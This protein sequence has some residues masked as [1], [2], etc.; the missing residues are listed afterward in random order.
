MDLTFIDENT[1]QKKQP[2]ARYIK[3]E[4]VKE[5]EKLNFAA[6]KIKY[7]DNPA[8]IKNSFRDDSANELT[9]CI[10][11]WLK[12]NGHFGGRVNTMGTYSQK[13][14]KYIRSGSRKGMADITSII[15][16]KHVSI[17]IKTGKDKLRPEQ[18]K[19]KSEV[20]AAGGVYIVASSYDNFLEQIKNI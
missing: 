14:G 13:L 20:E 12:L 8:V 17:E 15:D 16:G 5:L 6:K 9:R 18:E 2:K 4:S 10:L 7:P 11:V 1:K 19:V 3:P